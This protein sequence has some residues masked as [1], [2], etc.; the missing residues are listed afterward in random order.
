MIRTL[1]AACR[2]WW[3]RRSLAVQ[4]VGRVLLYS[5]TGCHL[6]DVAWQQ[7]EAA[8]LRY[9]FSLETVDIETDP[10]LVAKHGNEIPVVVIN[11]RIRFRGRINPVLLERLLTA[12]ARA[13]RKSADGS[14]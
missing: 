8:R 3:G 10:E 11:G 1:F 6:C 14:A 7:L 9:Y 4:P 13:M 12:E 5:R 2:T